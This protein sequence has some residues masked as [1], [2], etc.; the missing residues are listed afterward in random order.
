MS[1]TSYTIHVSEAMLSRDLAGMVRRELFRAGSRNAG[2]LAFDDDGDRD[3]GHGR[4]PRI[5]EW[6]G[7]TGW[8]LLPAKLAEI[9]AAVSEYHAGHRPTAEDIAARIG[10]GPQRRDLQVV[11]SVAVVPVYGVISGRADMFSDASGGTS[12]QRLQ[13][14]FRDAMADD[15]IRAIVLDVDSPGG[16]TDLLPE[17]A[18]EIRQARGKGKPIAAVANT[19]AA[20]AAYWLASQ[21]DEVIATPSADVGSVGVYAAHQ[22]LSGLQEKTGV[23]TTLISAGKFKVEGNPFEPLS[24]EAR[25]AIQSMVDEFYGM[26]VGDV[27]KG[28]RVSVSTVRSDFGEG[29][30]LSARKALAAGMIDRIDTLEATVK[31]LGKGGGVSLAA[32]EPAGDLGAADTGTTFTAEALALRDSADHLRDRLTSLAEV[33]RGVLSNAKRDALTACPSALR[34]TADAI[35][36]VLAATDPQAAQADSTI[37]DPGFDLEFDVL[38]ARLR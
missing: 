4:I 29:R 38:N 18:A 19:R 13:S 15:A 7:S 26:F 9:V 33:D 21:A 30:M 14:S 10:G 28:R 16:S 5:V 35:D 3:G 6:V 2:G 31:R 8:A 23:K 36:G 20:S 11:G 17:L 25:D 37:T 27:A 34:E 24:E 22:D 32:P 12:I 1:E